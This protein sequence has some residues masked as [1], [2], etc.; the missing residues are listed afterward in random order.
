MNKFLNQKYNYSLS[1]WEVIACFILVLIA[2]VAGGIIGFIFNYLGFEDLGF[3]LSFFTGFSLALVLL[4]YLKKLPFQVYKDML[5]T[6]LKWKLWLLAIGIYASILPFSE[7]TTSL[8]PTE[9]IPFLEKIYQGFIETF[10]IILS[11]P[12]SAF[13]TICILAPILEES[14]FRGFIL[15][16]LLN[17]KTHPIWAIFFSGILFGFA[18]LNPWQFIGAGILGICFGF[19]YWRTGS[20]LLCIFLHF[21]NNFISFV[22]SL[23]SQNVEE[24]FFEENFLLIGSSL[25]LF[26]ILIYTMIKITPHAH[27]RY[28][29]SK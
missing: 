26:F 2:Q 28:S 4:F 14:I 5:L 29:E 20:L 17:S 9:G 16:G 21:I 8:I 19:I 6:G 3:I 25:L 13:I 1:F 23:K 18:H 15:Q 22:Y 12:I 11:K 7:Y 27:L 24:P 10:K